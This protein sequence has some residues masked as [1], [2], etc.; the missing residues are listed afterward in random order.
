MLFFLSLLCL[1]PN[2]CQ[3]VAPSLPVNLTF[4]THVL[5]AKW[6]FKISLWPC[7]CSYSHLFCGNTF[8]PTLTHHLHV[9]SHFLLSCSIFV[10]ILCCSSWQVLVF[11][12]D[13]FLQEQLFSQCLDYIRTGSLMS[14][15]IDL[16]LC[17]SEVAY[18]SMMCDYTNFEYSSSQKA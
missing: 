5:F 8:L 14:S 15:S 1:A 2:F 4:F 13:G 7:V 6:V 17:N 11:G 10:W 3:P 16:S 18:F 12:R 9:S